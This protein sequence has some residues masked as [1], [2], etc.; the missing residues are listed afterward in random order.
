[1]GNE[2]LVRK[3]PRRVHCVADE[4]KPQIDIPVVPTEEAKDEDSVRET[5]PA[6]DA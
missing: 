3:H 2:V 4:Q 1:M 5:A 6:E